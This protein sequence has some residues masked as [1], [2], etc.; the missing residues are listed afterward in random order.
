[1]IKG[2]RQCDLVVK[3][4]AMEM[5]DRTD[6][7]KRN[8]VRARRVPG[9]ERKKKKGTTT[10]R[11]SP[12]AN[13]EGEKKKALWRVNDL[14]RRVNRTTLNF[15]PAD[16]EGSIKPSGKKRGGGRKKL[17]LRSDHQRQREEWTGRARN[18]GHR[19]DEKKKEKTTSTAPSRRERS[20]GKRSLV[21]Q[22]KKGTEADRAL[23]PG[24][25]HVLPAFRVT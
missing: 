24:K 21:L 23:M 3:G 4:S 2:K 5:A 20:E 10:T 8:Q 19:V 7:K 18:K 6:A 9:S 22:R 25:K 14:D 12:A 16:R 15:A 1:M 17:P 11:L 13:Q